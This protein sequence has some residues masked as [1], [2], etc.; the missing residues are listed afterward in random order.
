M[1]W[2]YLTLFVLA[3]LTPQFIAREVGFLREEDVEALLIFCFGAFGFMIYLAKEKTLLKLIREKLHLEKQTSLITRD[4]SDSYSYIGEMNR[5]LDI[6]QDFIFDLPKV[7]AVALKDESNIYTSLL[8]TVSLLGKTDQVALC[9]VHTRNKTM[10]CV[11]E[12]NGA[13]FF[14]QSL[15]AAELLA[16]GK[17]FWQTNDRAVVRSPRQARGVSAF[18]VFGKTVNRIEDSD[19]FKILVSQALLLYMFEGKGKTLRS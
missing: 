7:T 15:T 5:K 2:I 18:L 9:F 19:V 12:K 17:Y 1:Y 3:I 8:E 11:Y 6:V 4:L 14:A 10:E 13:N 16:E